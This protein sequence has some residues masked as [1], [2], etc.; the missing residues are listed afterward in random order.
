M[1]LVLG[2]LFSPK[3]VCA[4]ASDFGCSQDLIP[5]MALVQLRVTPSITS[6]R[7]HAAPRGEGSCLVSTCRFAQCLHAAIS[8]YHFRF[9]LKVRVG[10]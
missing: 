1:G 8:A 9:A 6:C 7:S 2:N 5:L 10:V 4:A 3:N